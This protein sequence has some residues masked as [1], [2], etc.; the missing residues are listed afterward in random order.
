MT[1]IVAEVL[2]LR[3][4]SGRIGVEVVDADLDLLV[5]NQTAR[6]DLRRALLDHHVVVLRGLYPTPEEH[7]A[8]ASAFGTPIAP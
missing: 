7:I 8:I 5:K 6:A 4:V 3:P 2:N 1:H